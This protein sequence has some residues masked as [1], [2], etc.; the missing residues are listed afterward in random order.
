MNELGL[1]AHLRSGLVVRPL[2]A[3]PR[4]IIYALLWP[5][6]ATVP[7]VAAMVEA[8]AA[9]ARGLRSAIPR[10]EAVARAGFS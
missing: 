3:W 8:V 6:M 5:D 4:R 7:A 10:S 2:R 1:Q 9:A